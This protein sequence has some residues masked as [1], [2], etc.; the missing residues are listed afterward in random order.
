MTL[1]QT[2][3][4]IFRLLLI[5]DEEPARKLLSQALACHGFQ[6]REAASGVEGLRSFGSGTECDVVLTDLKMPQM[7]GIEF[8]TRAKEIDPQVQ[9]LVLTAFG[10]IET[11]VEAM[12]SGAVDYLTKPVE[13]IEH[14]AHKLRAAASHR[15]ALRDNDRL[16]EQVTRSVTGQLLLGDSPVIRKVRADIARLASSDIPVL[17]SG[18]SGTGK[19]LVARSLH[20]LSSRQSAPL[21]AVNIAAI[22]ETLFEAELF[23]VEKGAYTGADK[24][25]RGL[26][27][28][29]HGGTLFLD[30]IGELPL[31]AQ[32]KLLRVLEQ[33]L[34]TPLGGTKEE[35]VDFRLLV[36]T[37]RDLKAE[38]QAGRFREDLYY[39]LSAA[40]IAIPS[41][42]DRGEDILLLASHFLAEIS[43]TRGMSFEIS[44]D[45]RSVLLGYSWPG[46][47]REL[48]H[49][50][51]RAAIR[52]EGNLIGMQEFDFLDSSV[53]RSPETTVQIRNLS[54]IEAEH[55]KLVL[56]ACQWNMTEA[57][58]LL[59]IHRNTLRQKIRDYHL[60]D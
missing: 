30:E 29:A 21:V 1:L 53:P 36:A 32:A 54:E 47:V 11:A 14:L 60:D 16:R 43:G 41:L 15:L 23:G 24:A 25:R 28:T 17:I 57:S 7:S 19:E 42:K 6:V 50:I 59:G 40:T 20:L 34:V 37:N 3:S 26:V 45:A 22:P 35:P 49:A 52:A 9:I 27:R 55:I 39:R 46:N 51:E 5:D 4:R 13:D 10:A 2:D 58:H 33:K 38:V 44:S 18:P 56:S 12:R 48:R 8:L 31:I